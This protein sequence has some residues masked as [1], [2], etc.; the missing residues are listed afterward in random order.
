MGRPYDHIY[1]T[2]SSGSRYGAMTCAGCAGPITEGEYRCYKRTKNYDWGFVLHH[3]ACCSTDPMWAKL[4][5]KRHAEANR[6]PPTLLE[7]A[8]QMLT[9][10]SYETEYDG[11]TYTICNSCD[12]QDGEHRDGCE[13]EVFRAIVARG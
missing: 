9:W 13:V 3:R 1:E 12:G 4:D 5:A 7:A 11:R 2:A 8:K 6:P 10:A